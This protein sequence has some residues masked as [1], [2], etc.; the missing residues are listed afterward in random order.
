[1][2]VF[3]V[4]NRRELGQIAFAADENPQSVHVLADHGLVL[5]EIGGLSRLELRAYSFK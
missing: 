2:R 5:V 1:L 4:A 3:D